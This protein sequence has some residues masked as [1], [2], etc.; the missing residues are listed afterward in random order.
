[1]SAVLRFEVAL[2]GGLAIG[3]AFRT[4]VR[5]LNVR[6]VSCGRPMLFGRPVQKQFRSKTVPLHDRCWR[7][8]IPRG[9]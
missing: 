8:L 5:A 4:C 9:E 3:W 2:L 6:C 1:M 7:K